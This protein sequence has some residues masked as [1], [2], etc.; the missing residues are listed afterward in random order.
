[1]QYNTARELMS[2]KEYG[3]SIHEMVKYAMGIEDRS[4]RQ[5][6]AEA[7]IE[8]MAI[9]SPQLKAIEDYQHKLWDHLFLISNYQLDVDSP[10]PIPTQALKEKKPEPLA[11]PKQKIR[12]N[13]FGKKF[14]DLF[15]KAMIEDDEEKKSGYIQVLANCMKVAYSNWHEENV[16]DDMVKDELF[17]MSKGKL[18]YEPGSRFNDFVDGVDGVTINPVMPKPFK[19]AFNHRNGRN[20]NSNH[21]TN[22]QPPQG[23]NSNK[24]NKFNRFKKKN[25]NNQM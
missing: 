3:R 1:M 13:H 2:I 12:W 16:H 15:E 22:I 14:E 5:K 20:G 19:R 4:V 9:L 23:S 10:Y 8:V 7:I 24:N 6:N 25:N 21:R 17:A 11:Y 18:L